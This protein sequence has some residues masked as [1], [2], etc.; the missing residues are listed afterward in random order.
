MFGN[1]AIY[2]DGWLARTIHRAPWQTGK[3]KP[4]KS[5]TWDLYN[6]R[7]DFSLTK[8]LASKQPDRLKELQALFMEEAEK[9][10]VLPI[11]DRT[12]ERVN[13]ALDG[14]PDLLG[15]RKF[16]TLY[17]GMNGMLE[18]TFMNVKNRSKTITAELV[19]PKEGAN[20]VILRVDVSVAGHSI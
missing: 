4:L 15:D 5:D 18:N 6:V 9:Y 1:R 2:H 11:D 20:G 16:L 10:H 8:N 7:E 17:D 14:R 13:P 3:Q 19:I 12:I